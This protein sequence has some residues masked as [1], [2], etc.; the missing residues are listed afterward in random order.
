M[1]S[2]IFYLFFFLEMAD[3]DNKLQKMK[4]LIRE[5][6]FYLEQNPEY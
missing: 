3:K 5:E 6:Y 2:V 4:P 1:I